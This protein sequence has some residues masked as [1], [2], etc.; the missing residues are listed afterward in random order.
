MGTENLLSPLIFNIYMSEL[1]LYFMR[2]QSK[3][4][5]TSV[6]KISCK[7]NNPALLKGFS[8][9]KATSY[10]RQQRQSAGVTKIYTERAFK[11][12][13]FLPAGKRSF[14]TIRRDYNVGA[15]RFTYNRGYKMMPRARVHPL[16][17]FVRY[18]NNL[19]V[20]VASGYGLA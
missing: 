1:D 13:Q 5:T 4:I 18:K 6:K 20:A 2:L 12:N 19:L 10:R 11:L 8:Q 3:R 9:V 7:Q 15:A 17:K 16:L 14:Q